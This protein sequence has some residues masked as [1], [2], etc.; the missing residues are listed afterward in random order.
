MAP[1]KKV[2]AKKSK[3]QQHV[4]KVLHELY[5]APDEPGSYGGQEALLRAVRK[6]LPDTRREQVEDWLAEQDT[7]TLHKP[8]RYK[9]PRKRVVVGGI[10]HQWQA[11]LADMSSL[12]QFNEGFTFLLTV[13]DILSKY[14][15]VV[16][17]KSKAKHGVAEAFASI[18]KQ[19]RKPLTL[20][21]DQGT[22]FLNDAVQGLLKREKVHFFTTYNVET[23]ASVVERFNRTLKT[24]MWRYFTEHQ[25][26]EYLPVLQKLVHAYNHSRHRSIGMAPVEVNDDNMEKVW[27]RLYAPKQKTKGQVKKLRRK[28]KREEKEEEKKR[29]E[30][31][32]RKPVKVGDWVRLS[33][34]RRTFKKGYLPNWSEELFSVVE[35]QKGDPSLYVVQDY[36]GEV[37]KGGMYPQ[38]VQKVVKSDNLYRI[39]K[40][41]D[42]P[43]RRKPGGRGYQ[44][45]VRWLGYGPQFDSWVDEKDV[46]NYIRRS[47][48]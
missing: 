8:V 13:I 47:Q 37:I 48:R 36:N 11:D 6:R 46:L 5:Y 38:E 32:K 17:L 18:F 40:V 3:G 25:T 1:R 14:A 35:V 22:E 45:K 23:K 43:R 42:E 10:D 39:E 16:P 19:G 29:S 7:Y 21:T 20:Q 44:V 26:R 4:E 41:L 27:Q 31:E 34:S 33:K 24:R 28:L 2:G 9:F 30:R 15:W 12:K